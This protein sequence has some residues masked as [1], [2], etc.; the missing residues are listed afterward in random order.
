MARAAAL[1]KAPPA[2]VAALS[3]AYME[4]LNGFVDAAHSDL[5]FLTDIEDLSD[6]LRTGF[7]GFF[8]AGMLDLYLSQLGY[9]FHCNGREL[10][11]KGKV[12]D[13]AYDASTGTTGQLIAA[14]AK[15]SIQ[16]GATLAAIRSDAQA[17]YNSQI[18]PH[19]GTTV[20]GATIVHGYAIGTGSQLKRGVCC[21]MHVQE[22]SWVTGTAGSAPPTKPTTPV[23]AAPPPTFQRPVGVVAVR[24]YRDVFRLLGTADLVGA[25]ESAL[26]ADWSFFKPSP[27]YTLGL[28]QW[29]GNQY[30]VAPQAGEAIRFGLRLDVAMSF[31]T[32]IAACIR[33]RRIPARFPEIPTRPEFAWGELLVQDGGAEFPDGLAY[34]GRSQPAMESARLVWNPEVGG[35]EYQS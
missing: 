19:L 23:S 1:S 25:I 4:M 8:G 30:A 24:H 21:E 12:F 14:E 29:R 32:G 26:H 17:G 18:T 28:T 22:S 31:L 35:P 5:T 34:F 7:S 13:L 15:G 27:V 2:V 16:G 11:P 20:H 6:N 9:I 3:R 10:I 33:D